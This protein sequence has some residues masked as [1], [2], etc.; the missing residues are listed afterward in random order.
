MAYVT[1][2]VIGFDIEPFLN[3]LETSNIVF[4]MYSIMV[5][6][7]QTFD[8]QGYTNVGFVKNSKT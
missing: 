7:R 6:D 2:K 5:Y 3:Y 8:Y 1:L 4:Q